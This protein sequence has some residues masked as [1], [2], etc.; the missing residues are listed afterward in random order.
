M[1]SVA[2]IGIWGYY[3]AQKLRSTELLNQNITNC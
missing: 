2:M 3:S 1:Q